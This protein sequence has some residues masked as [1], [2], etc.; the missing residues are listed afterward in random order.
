MPSALLSDR[1]RD[2]L[3]GELG[4]LSGDVELQV[5]IRGKADGDLQESQ[6]VVRE[7]A[8]ELVAAGP[9]R[10]RLSIADLD[11]GDRPHG[12]GDQLS[13]LDGVPVLQFAQPGAAPRIAYMG[14]PG[15]Y[16]F[17]TVVDTI[18][19]IGDGGHGIKDANVARLSD[20]DRP[21]EV[22]VFVTPSCPYCPSAASLAFRLAMASPQVRG[23]TVEAMEFPELST[24]HQVSGVPRIVVNRAQAF[25]GA[26]PED[27]FVG[28]VL[29][30]AEAHPM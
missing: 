9:D 23:V 8:E 11:A 29:R 26:L 27:A 16:E 28:E 18:R 2:Q 12:V 14:I 20:L 21:V 7:V 25:V 24:R 3:R 5:V 6:Q 1:I 15:G 10:V 19:R 13:R 22:M 4:A 17:S 30:L